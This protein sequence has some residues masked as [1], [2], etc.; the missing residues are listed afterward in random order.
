MNKIIILLVVI[1]AG[2]F[3]S[4]S[5][6]QEKK[7][8]TVCFK[9]NMDC[10]NCENKL[11]EYLKFEK[12]VKAL[13]VDYVSN[14]ILIEYKNGKNSDEGLAKSVEKKGYKIEKISLEEYKK[15][16]AA[17]QEETSKKSN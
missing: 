9:S 17:S 10:A 3:I 1:F 7:T 5:V 6:A 4:E 8:K 2:S 16:V 11:N 14:T 15:L 13:K 12:G